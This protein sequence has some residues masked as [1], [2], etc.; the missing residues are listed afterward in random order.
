MQMMLAATMDRVDT[1]LCCSLTGRNPDLI[2]AA[3]IAAQYGA[4]T[5]ALTTAGTPLTEAVGLA[6]TIAVP[7]DGDVLGPT[8]MRY[9]FMTAIDML[10]YVVAIRAQPAAREKLR[11]IKQQFMTYRD[12]DDTQPLCD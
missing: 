11:R 3:G 2:R 12:E 6:L 8:S 4:A 9:G 5:V 7:D 1:L 10:A